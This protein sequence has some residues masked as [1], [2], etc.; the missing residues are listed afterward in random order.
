MTALRV[1]V[2][3]PK[4]RL[5]EAADGFQIVAEDR[6]GHEQDAYSANFNTPGVK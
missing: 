6:Q 1:F 3:L 5:A 2:T 4:D